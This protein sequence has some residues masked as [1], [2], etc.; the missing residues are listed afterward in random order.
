MR[1]HQVEIHRVESC[2]VESCQIG[3]S[4][5]FT[6][7][8]MIVVI[9][10][11]GV[12]STIGSSFVV[13]AMDS[14]RTAEVRNKLVQRGRLAIEQM[15]REV[16]MALPNAIRISAS[17]DC[18]EFLPIVSSASYRGRLPDQSN[19]ASPVN[20]I[21]TS[22]FELDYGTARQVIVAPF[23]NLEVYSSASTAARVQIGT[24]G[25][26]PHSIV[27]LNSAH[28]FFRNSINRRVYITDNPI[29][30]CLSGQNLVRYSNYGFLTTALSNIDPGGNADI[31]SHQVSSLGTAFI[32]SPGSE[33]TNIELTINLLFSKESMS[34]DLNH[35]VL[36]RNV[37]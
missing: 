17:G 35:Q 13:T 36:I 23:S 16:H 30:Y 24:L 3:K 12:I 14:Y 8:E 32:L 37:P 4:Q 21:N 20:Q 19:S 5:G 29:R 25:S 6:L 33:D 22:N 9:V 1:D 10:V 11:L 18:F 2:R 31:V 7:I 27:P 15:T 34:I 28:R 26:A